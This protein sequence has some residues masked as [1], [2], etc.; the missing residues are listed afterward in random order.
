MIKVCYVCQY[1]KGE[2]ENP[3]I[4][5]FTE[6]EV[7]RMGL[8]LPIDKIRSIY[9]NWNKGVDVIPRKLIHVDRVEINTIN[10]MHTQTVTGIKLKVAIND[11]YV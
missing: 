6:D 5:I 4:E 10:E 1:I 11:I 3:I 7:K 8:G 9:E 2:D